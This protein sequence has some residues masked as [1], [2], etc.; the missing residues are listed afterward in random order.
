MIET[1]KQVLVVQM[2]AVKKHVIHNEQQMT[3]RGQPKDRSVEEA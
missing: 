2:V 1:Q 3:Q